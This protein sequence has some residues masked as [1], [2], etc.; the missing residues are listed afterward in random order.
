MVEENKHVS[1]IRNGKNM[2]FLQVHKPSI[3]LVNL[4]Y[5][6]KL[7]HV[8]GCDHVFEVVLEAEVQRLAHLVA[9]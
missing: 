1:C 7:Y 8:M 9:G 2:I 3:L 4:E 6:K 5:F